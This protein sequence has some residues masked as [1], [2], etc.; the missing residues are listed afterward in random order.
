METDTTPDAPATDVAQDSTA[1]AP[2]HD[3]PL[4]ES[5]EK[6]L[7]EFKRR[8]REAE[9]ARKE[10]EAKVQSFEDRDKSEQEKLAE[11]ATRA[12][13]ELQ[14]ARAETLRLKVAAEAG[15]PA[16][17]QEFLT[18]ADEDGLKA[19]ASKLKAVAAATAA[20]RTPADLG[21]GQR[22][23]GKASQLTRAEL[24]RMT[25]DQIVQ[26]KA[27]GRLDDLLGVTK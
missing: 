22:G 19:Q 11:R 14:A 7:A 5:G 13:A 24:K 12:E 1:A 8:A 23:T 2:P 17:L 18:A 25:S 15:L 20:P 16:E 4:G 26:A 21:Q 10:L 3:A 27:E 6:A 9:R